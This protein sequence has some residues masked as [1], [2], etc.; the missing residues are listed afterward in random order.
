MKKLD[1]RSVIIGFLIAVIGFMSIGATNTTF[2]SI[3]VGEIILKNDDL[4]IKNSKQD[5]IL[6]IVGYDLAHGL[7]MYN[8]AGES[9]ALIGENDNGNG[10]ISIYNRSGKRTSSLSHTATGDGSLNLFTKTGRESIL[11]SHTEN[12]NGVVALFNKHQKQVIYL[13]TTNEGDGQIVLSDR[14]GE[15]QWGVTG[16]RK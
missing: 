10:E 9:V 13:S 3:T 1:P 4:K 5:D 16:K 6:L 2:D 7:I 14:Y 12:D 8:N 15:G 11:L